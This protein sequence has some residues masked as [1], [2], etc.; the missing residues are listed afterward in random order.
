MED[1]TKSNEQQN[2]DL[3]IDDNKAYNNENSDKYYKNKIRRQ[4]PS[5]L[6]LFLF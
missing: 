5:I 3:S 1:K 6:I 2:D 4:N